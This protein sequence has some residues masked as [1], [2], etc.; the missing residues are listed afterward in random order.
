MLEGWAGRNRRILCT[1]TYISPNFRI[2][3][4]PAA[5]MIS[6]SNPKEQKSAPPAQPLQP[7]TVLAAWRH[8][9]LIGGLGGSAIS[10]RVKRKKC[11]CGPPNNTRKPSV[12]SST[13]QTFVPSIPRRP[14]SHVSPGVARHNRQSLAPTPAIEPHLESRRSPP[15][16]LAPSTSSARRR[17]RVSLQT[18]RASPI[19]NVGDFGSAGRGAADAGEEKGTLGESSRHFGGRAHSGVRCLHGRIGGVP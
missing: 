15:A 1:S 8:G 19:H 11:Q 14:P 13:V 12:S 18:P 10:K 16:F 5:V 7:H 4:P 17:L 6:R 2:V 9:G 3:L